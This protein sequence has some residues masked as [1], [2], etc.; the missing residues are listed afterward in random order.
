MA[1]ADKPVT[2]MDANFQSGGSSSTAIAGGTVPDDFD[3][4][5]M[6]ENPFGGF[7]TTEGFGNEDEEAG[8]ET[9]DETE[10]DTEDDQEGEEEDEQ[11]PDEFGKKGK[12]STDPARYWQS[13]H[14]K[15]Q[16]ELA[17]LRAKMEQYQQIVGGL[18][19]DP[20]AARLLAEHWTRG[21][22]GAEVQAPS[23]PMPPEDFDPMLQ[24]TPG[25]S[26][27]KFRQEAERYQRELLKRELAGEVEQRV[28]GKLRPLQEERQAAQIR[29][30]QIAILSKTPIPADKYD[31]FLSWK[32]SA[33][34]LA[35]AYMRS[36]DLSAEKK[37][38]VDGKRKE[39]D[40]VKSN[41]AKAGALKK[42]GTGESN[43]RLDDST[44]FIRGLAAVAPRL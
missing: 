23:E 27:Y 4:F 38:E 9:P 1:K 18:E 29:A 14:D 34:D 15:K 16:S 42:P 3:D 5:D 2:S 30:Q 44:S 17:S 33:D 11:V 10:L 25:T 35:A 36:K 20:E 43:S 37:G 39:F 21:K 13:E 24:W 12:K 28:D 31:D 40:K 6:S 32:P 7:V 41:G 22:S 26:S 8:A 19:N